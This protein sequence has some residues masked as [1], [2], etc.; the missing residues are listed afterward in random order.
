LGEQFSHF[1]ER[2]S[3]KR[4]PSSNFGMIGQLEPMRLNLES[5]FN[6]VPSM[7]LIARIGRSVTLV[8]V[9]TL[10][11][12]HM[13][14]P[15]DVHPG[16]Q[17]K[18]PFTEAMTSMMQWKL[19]H[20]AC[21]MVWLL[22]CLSWCVWA[23]LCKVTQQPDSKLESYQSGTFQFSDAVLGFGA[24][25]TL[26]VPWQLGI[27]RPLEMHCESLNQPKWSS[28]QLH[29][30]MMKEVRESV[31]W[32]VGWIVQLFP[33]VDLK[34]T[35]KLDG[36]VDVLCAEFCLM[37]LLSNCRCCLGGNILLNYFDCTPPTLENI[38]EWCSLAL[39]YL[40]L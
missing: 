34:L 21:P 35:W 22:L 39:K 25:Q 6:R 17:S 29:N 15:V 3:G 19:S 27:S 14:V 2:R 13:L 28:H 37:H 31:E 10:C 18:G 38:L 36:C 20:F 33:L 26:Q 16:K 1:A 32:L 8:L 4:F 11:R 23:L 12:I 30:C 24:K 9:W 5:I 7:W 40:L